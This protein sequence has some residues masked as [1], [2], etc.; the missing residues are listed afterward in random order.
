MAPITKTG[1]YALLQS[2]VLTDA[3]HKDKLNKAELE[4]AVSDGYAKYIGD[5]VLITDAGY[6]RYDK[7][8]DR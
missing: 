5:H 4:K 1:E 7:L 2:L 3:V 8:N 6:D